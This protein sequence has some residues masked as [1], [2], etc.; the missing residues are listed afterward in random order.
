MRTR[1]R[2]TRDLSS[3][4]VSVPGRDLERAAARA[5]LIA[6][7][8]RSDDYW[9]AGEIAAYAGVVPSAVSNWQTRYGNFPA[10]I[11]VGGHK[12]WRRADVVA[13]LESRG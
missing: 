11:L 13:W 2:V 3:Y 10:P 9:S 1:R 7:R 12:V 4:R 5:R 6:R 8:E